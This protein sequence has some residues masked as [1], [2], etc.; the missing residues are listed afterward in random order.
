[1]LLDVAALPP[2]LSTHHPVPV[3]VAI[4]PLE[5]TV[6]C[7]DPAR[8]SWC[9][10]RA[11]NLLLSAPTTDRR[12][13]S[14]PPLLLPHH[15]R[16]GTKGVRRRL[17]SESESASCDCAPA[18]R[19]TV[20]DSREVKANDASHNTILDGWIGA[21]GPVV[22]RRYLSAIW[23]VPAR[24]PTSVRCS[25]MPRT[26]FS[27]GQFQLNGECMNAMAMIATHYMPVPPCDHE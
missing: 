4:H 10:R 12:F 2:Q 19:T 15:L 7:R 14:S 13:H 23:K 6:R 18:A 20:V 9:S 27:R 8:Y 24:E 16:H 17:A 3:V 22:L 26:Q 1:M 5:C 21:L 11:H 25:C